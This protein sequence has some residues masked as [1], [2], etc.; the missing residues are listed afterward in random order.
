MTCWA[1]VGP[2]ASISGEI[3]SFRGA[4]SG[5]PNPNILSLPSESPGVAIMAMAEGART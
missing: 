1:G 2:K 4:D 3:S 5:D